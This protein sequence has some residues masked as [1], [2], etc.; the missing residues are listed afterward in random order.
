[1]NL[2][3]KII[4]F[5]STRLRTR[6]SNHGKY[7]IHEFFAKIM[8]SIELVVKVESIQSSQYFLII[9]RCDTNCLQFTP[10]MIKRLEKHFF[11]QK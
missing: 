6:A 2:E 5:T 1:M 4:K 3:S 10:H 7:F 8:A 9:L 11:N